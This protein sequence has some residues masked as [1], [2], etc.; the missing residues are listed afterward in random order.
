MFES[1]GFTLLSCVPSGSE[2]PN[3]SSAPPP[4]VARTPGSGSAAYA[5]KLSEK[6]TLLALQSWLF[7]R[8]HLQE[9]GVRM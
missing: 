5:V 4:D 3:S 8:A 2:V 7:E 1:C 9:G 6:G